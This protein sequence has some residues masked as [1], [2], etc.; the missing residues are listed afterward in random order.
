MLDARR[1]LRT[2]VVYRPEKGRNPHRYALLV[3]ACSRCGAEIRVVPR[4]VSSSSGLCRPCNAKVQVA[5]CGLG[6]WHPRPLKPAREK[7]RRPCASVSTPGYSTV[8]KPTTEL[9]AEWERVLSS[10][11]LQMW[12]G[13]PPWLCYGY[14]EVKGNFVPGSWGDR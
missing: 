1:A 5:A 2:D 12:R 6:R 14:E 10:F 9:R 3:F 4:N 11:G 8:P 7:A 13:A